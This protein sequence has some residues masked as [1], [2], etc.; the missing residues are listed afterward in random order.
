M[1]I[2][3]SIH[4]AD[5]LSNGPQCMYL[6]SLSSADGHFGAS[7]S[8]TANRAAMSTGGACV[9]WNYGLRISVIILSATF[10]QPEEL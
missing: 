4:A 8:S 9:F 1:I 5:W 10:A 6:S 3:R 7:M 2:S